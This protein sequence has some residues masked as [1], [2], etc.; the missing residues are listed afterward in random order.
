M[1][2]SGDICFTVRR[3]IN[4]RSGHN[5]NQVPD[6]I[7]LLRRASAR[8][9]I[10]HCGL[11]NARQD[12][13]IDA[14]LVWDGLVNSSMVHRGF[15]AAENEALSARWVFGT[16]SAEACVETRL[17]CPVPFLKIPQ[18]TSRLLKPLSSGV[19]I[20]LVDND[21]GAIRLMNRILSNV[22]TMRFATNGPEGLRVAQQAPP[23]LI[24]PD[25]EMPGMS[26]FD[27]LKEIKA[28]PSLSEVPVIFVTSHAG[29][30]FE[31][32]A[33]QMGASDFITKPYRAPAVMARVNTQLRFKGL[34]DELRRAATVDGLTGVAN[35]R[36]FDEY[37][38][39][40]WHRAWRAGDPVS[41]LMIDVDHF[42]LFNDRY[43]HPRGDTCLHLVAGILVAECHR[44][45]DFVA[46]YGGGEFVVLLPQTPR[47]G[48]E[49]VAA[50]ILRA[51]NAA[52]VL[53]DRSPTAAH[54][55][56]SIGI[57]CTDPGPADVRC[58]N[59]EGARVSAPGRTIDNLIVAA[60][61]ALYGAKQAGRALPLPRSCR[62]W[63]AGLTCG[64]GK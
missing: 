11:C 27:L 26:G 24:L 62:R 19:S 10:P 9:D 14:L 40:E 2:F 64:P 28:D 41:L 4:S 18:A 20:L 35:R 38:A 45:A 29:A 22:G 42:K 52:C 25:V 51:I 61:E 53:H 56:V 54:V 17:K 32:T 48:G 47:A 5:V 58:T 21:P 60:D 1:H 57:A 39:R 6:A 23:D 59:A 55:T 34:S 8:F 49:W 37:F 30:D 46:C 44:P 7:E 63:S 36:S 33:L 15:T 31:V 16:K 50:R 12:T 3:C 43:G 13:L